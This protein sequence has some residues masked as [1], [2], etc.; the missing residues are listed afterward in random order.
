MENNKKDR[1]E[2]VSGKGYKSKKPVKKRKRNKPVFS[3]LKKYIG[4]VIGIV[5]IALVAIYVNGTVYYT[6][7]FYKGTHIN[8]IDV[9]KLTADEVENVNKGL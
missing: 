2:S 1:Y 9:S 3:N 5:C 4:I 8:G 6:T 7:H